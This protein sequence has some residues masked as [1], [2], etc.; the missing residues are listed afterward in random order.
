LLRPRMHLYAVP[1]ERQ[2]ANVST[3]SASA[4]LVDI[5]RDH[6]LW[7]RYAPVADELEDHP[8]E[9]THDG[10]SP[11]AR[12]ERRSRTHAIG[13]ANREACLSSA[14]GLERIAAIDQSKIPTADSHMLIE[15][16]IR[17]GGRRKVERPPQEL[18]LTT[19]GDDLAE[20]YAVLPSRVSHPSGRCQLH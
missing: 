17:H 7:L 1:R 2:Q 15:D 19:V 18:P 8:M 13:S 5:G 20:R 12:V 3:A 4:R 6:G 9:I 14:D 11:V 16:A 10:M